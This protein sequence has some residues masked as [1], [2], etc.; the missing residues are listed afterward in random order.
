MDEEWTTVRMSRA[1]R[2]YLEE[3]SVNYR[4]MFGIKTRESIDKIL[5]RIFGIKE[6]K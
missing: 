1:V 3:N 5:R 2:I 6:D 4:K